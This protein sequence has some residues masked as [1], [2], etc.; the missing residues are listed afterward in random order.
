[1]RGSSKLST[2][3]WLST[4]LVFLL[5]ANIFVILPRTV[6][7][8]PSELKLQDSLGAEI[9]EVAGLASTVHVRITH[10]GS[11]TDSKARNVLKGVRVNTSA[12][13]GQYIILDLV[14]T[15]LNS[16][17][18]RGVFGVTTGAST[19]ATCCNTTTH[20]YSFGWVTGDGKIKVGA[21]LTNLT[22]IPPA[23]TG[24]A[25]KVV[26]W[27]DPF[28][29]VLTVHKTA[30][31]STTGGGTCPGAL[32][33]DALRTVTAYGDSVYI[34]VC[35]PDLNRNTAVAEHPAGLLRFWSPSEPAGKTVPLHEASANSNE[36]FAV[37]AVQDRPSTSQ[38]Q[39]FVGNREKITVRYK[40]NAPA[41]AD[42][43]LYVYWDAVAAESVI[44]T[45]PDAAPTPANNIDF[46]KSETGTICFGLLVA[47]TTQVICDDR[48]ETIRGPT[49]TTKAHHLYGLSAT[50]GK[51]QVAV[52]DT[53]QNDGTVSTDV[54]DDDER[55][56]ITGFTLAASGVAG[57][58]GL[59]L[60][61]TE[62]GSGVFVGDF[63][64][65]ACTAHVTSP[66]KLCVGSPAPANATITAT[67]NDPRDH[68]GSPV[69]KTRVA[70]WH[71]AAAGILTLNRKAY[72]GLG[73]PDIGD[74]S[75]HPTYLKLQLEDMDANR[76]VNT[77]DEVTVTVKS[78]SDPTTG[79]SVTLK[80]T[81]VNTGI[82]IQRDN[83]NDA[84][85]ASNFVKFS[86]SATSASTKT[87]KVA[88]GA[89]ITAEYNDLR[90]PDGAPVLVRSAVSVWHQ[91]TT[92]QLSFEH[93]EYLES[94]A[95]PVFGAPGRL[96]VKD[97]D[98]NDPYAR[99]QVPVTLLN[100]GGDTLT[101]TARET[102]TDT[103]IFVADFRF[104]SGNS[105]GAA[106]PPQFKVAVGAAG[107]QVRFKYQDLITASN[108]GQNVNTTSPTAQWKTDFASFLVRYEDATTRQF[109]ATA[110]TAKNTTGAADAV[111][112]WAGG[113]G[114]R[115]TVGYAIYDDAGGIG[116][117][118]TADSGLCPPK[119]ITGLGAADGPRRGGTFKIYAMQ[120]AGDAFPTHNPTWYC[121]QAGANEVGVN[122]NGDTIT[123]S[124]KIGLV[125]KTTTIDVKVSNAT[126]RFTTSNV[127]SIIQRQA[128]YENPIHI[129]VDDDA[130][131]RNLTTI[132]HV[133]AKV[134][135][136]VQNFGADDCPNAG[137]TAGF[138][139]LLLSETGPNTGVFSGSIRTTD[140]AADQNN[141]VFHNPAKPHPT[142]PFGNPLQAIPEAFAQARVLYPTDATPAKGYLPTYPGQ[143]STIT[144]QDENEA[145]KR[146]FGSN[147][148]LII[149]M[150]DDNY[151]SRRFRGDEVLAPQGGGRQN[152][153]FASTVLPGSE[154]VFVNV[155]KNDDNCAVASDNCI[156]FNTGDVI[157]GLSFTVSAGGQAAQAIVDTNVAD[158]APAPDGSVDC[159]DIKITPLSGQIACLSVNPFTGV[160]KYAGRCPT[161][162]AAACK[163]RIAYTYRA[164]STGAVDPPLG[165]YRYTL[166]NAGN[167]GKV[168]FGGP[169]PGTWGVKEEHTIKTFTTTVSS[170]AAGESKT[171]TMTFVGTDGDADQGKYKATINTFVG[172]GTSPAGRIKVQGSSDSVR[173][174]YQ[175]LSLPDG[176]QAGD[177]LNHFK[178]R[179]D[180]VPWSPA[181]LAALTIT[182]TNAYGTPQTGD[183]F[184]TFLYLKVVD[185]DSHRTDRRDTVTVKVESE[186]DEENVVLRE[187]GVSGGEF[188]G[189]VKLCDGCGGNDGDAVLQV[190][191]TTESLH[192]TL[193]DLHN[194]EGPSQT[195]SFTR[196]WETSVDGVLTV[197][198]SDPAGGAPVC[199]SPCVLKGRG[200][201]LYLQVND[202]DSDLTGGLDVVSVTV[203]SPLEEE[204]F[205]L[206][207]TGAH[208]G[209]FQGE[210]VRFES[211][212]ATANN[213]RL[214]VQHGDRL[215]IVYNDPHGAAG[216]PKTITL[217][218]PIVRWD[219][220]HTATVSYLSPGSPAVFIGTRPANLT[221]DVGDI[222]FAIVS[223]QD[224][225][226]NTNPNTIDKIEDQAIVSRDGAGTR[227]T[228][229]LDLWETAPNSGVFVGRFAFTI[230][231]ADS[232]SET[233]TS[234]SNMLLH[235]ANLDTVRISYTDATN[236]DGNNVTV[237][238][239]AS[240]RSHGSGYIFFDKTAYV[241]ADQASQIHP[242]ITLYDGIVPAP[243]LSPTVADTQVVTVTSNA[244]STGISVTLQ[245][246]GINTGIFT[247]QIDLTEGASSGTSTPPQLKV[248]K[249]NDIIVVLYDP[250]DEQST[251]HQADVIIADTV[252]PVSTIEVSPRQPNAL[253]WYNAST[254]TI[255][256]NATDLGTVDSIYYHVTQLT[257]THTPL[258]S[259]TGHTRVEGNS[260]SFTLEDISPVLRTYIVHY[261]AKDLSGNVEDVKVATYKWDPDPPSGVVLNVQATAI[262]DG[263]ARVTWEN[264]TVMPVDLDKFI[265]YRNNT[266][267]TGGEVGKALRVFEDLPP[268]D[269]TYTYK[270]KM[271]DEAAHLGQFSDA[272]N[273]VSTDRTKPVL[274]LIS[275]TPATFDVRNAPGS[276]QLKLRATDARNNLVNVTADVQLG[277]AAAQRYVMTLGTNNNW[278]ATF[279]ITATTPVGVYTVTFR[280]TDL[281]GNV[282]V[283]NTTFVLTGPD[284]VK[285]TITI[286]PPSGS[287]LGRGNPITIAVSDNRGVA[288][289]QYALDGGAFVDHQSVTPNPLQVSYQVQTTNL[290]LGLHSMTVRARDTPDGTSQNTETVTYTF[291]L[292]EPPEPID[293]PTD[294]F[295]RNVKAESQKDGS[296]KVSWTAPTSS[297]VLK[298]KTIKGYIVW[299]AASPFERHATVYGA[300][301]TTHFDRDN[302][303][304]GTT[305]K[306]AVS[307]FAT[308]NYG[309]VS[310]ISNVVGFVSEDQIPVSPPVV[311]GKTSSKTSD[312]MRFILLVGLPLLA[313]VILIVVFVMI[314]GRSGSKAPAAAKTETVQEPAP[315]AASKAKAEPKPAAGVAEQRHALRCPQCQ[316]RF[317]VFGRKPIVTNCPNCGRKGILR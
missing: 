250:A 264:A 167:E 186:G 273:S 21:P 90:G 54:G 78:T 263:K 13:A 144:I 201:L 76:D 198:E 307:W 146:S 216:G 114:V 42:P 309:N 48:V 91:A 140:G 132:D 10:D 82:F 131:R 128:G 271:K 262:A 33:T 3:L 98:M 137:P 283:G 177:N 234:A 313:V 296:I 19:N 224:G 280:G 299:R 222:P 153:A 295:L 127:N 204:T 306:Y 108:P 301:A 182:Q 170:Q 122:N 80:E 14:E 142:A 210:P 64:I 311:A 284:L 6:E 138:V 156:S 24:I 49:D 134:C 165:P 286:T 281:V 65:G 145:T 18:F 16:A 176:T 113:N 206:D 179:S 101:I 228:E 293:L 102:G 44:S 278:T 185:T 147:S 219:E 39:L 282:G 77:K 159:R 249:P 259:I 51:F 57:T 73:S 92:A 43:V 151:G 266:A 178:S 225:D 221:A 32:S 188:R 200:D 41:T 300:D 15:D 79:L 247:K 59:T 166:A 7:A 9:N 173:F 202:A 149:K 58:L 69:T 227:D 288:L 47:T 265:L 152:W 120:L 53:D 68:T 193:S 233:Q 88:E 163:A 83:P 63:D 143:E 285:P 254:P 60:N 118:V 230:V 292:V 22:V 30:A 213:G 70:Y 75:N 196:D 62:A 312:A 252:K 294:L 29:G 209:I 129:R 181:A 155:S 37:F 275:A 123:L 267:I 50:A 241:A 104:T 287:D 172:T 199:V 279:N 107:D 136:A 93:G 218:D 36:F 314:R 229:T 180:K 214:F 253:G 272:S 231:A 276:I 157:D 85:S 121:D 238:K 74:K 315:A 124:V 270:V 174:L 251:D 96:L 103:G 269:G 97:L 115:E 208:T 248:N 290:A 232:A 27:R 81:N 111:E 72:A 135:V 52:V 189:V 164:M 2:R 11:N 257:H 171:L 28:T 99:D 308:D 139:M 150:T 162:P 17:E 190:T 183:L 67:Y 274:S 184:G 187:T 217:Q 148:K 298:G 289:V 195:V 297:D 4:L 46:L 141:L 66:P 116:A 154:Y 1:M 55:D 87:I 133:E 12:A 95:G 212:T 205:T 246:T 305:Y 26:K 240:W 23:S 71:A 223:V 56:Q 291:T 45:N 236:V 226:R 192:F 243:G 8:V 25:S 158:A 242:V 203:R 160:V 310:S 317:E 191:G 260:T 277:S 215:E 211:D 220:T 40:D 86:T 244:D 304:K 125:T 168:H 110:R 100:N 261:H 207:E 105:D 239:D 130:G 5:L 245:E 169:I 61:E 256:I 84:N 106:N 258:N 235:V 89:Q 38:L 161:S 237:T 94:G 316:H 20:P 31:R 119:D 109:T 268:T 35:D 34:R 112:G 175:D 194:A 117:T 126:A 255:Y 197:Y 303:T 302:V